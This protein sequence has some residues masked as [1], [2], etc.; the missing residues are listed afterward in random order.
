MPLP[1]PATLPA[2]TWH[3]IWQHPARWLAF[4]FGSGLLRPAPG[5]WGTLVAWLLWWAL[6]A[7]LGLS[8]TAMAVLL[9]LAFALGGWACQR[10][11]QDLGVSDHGGMVWDEMVAF[12]LVLWLVP[13]HALAQALAFALFRL[14]DI[15]KPVPIR[16]LDARCQNGW[17]VMLDDL[18]AAGYTVLALFALQRLGWLP[19]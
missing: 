5:T 1:H 18:L 15:V 19:W 9:T 4:G 6:L 12:W 10:T 17:G 8:D 16:Q 2:P 14:F 13:S 3:W 11:G 7:R